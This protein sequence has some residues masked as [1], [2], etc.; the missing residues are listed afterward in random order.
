MCFDCATFRRLSDDALRRRRRRRKK[1]EEEGDDDAK[2]E[3]MRPFLVL[4]LLTTLFFCSLLGTRGDLHRGD[5]VPTSARMQV[6]SSKQR[7]QWMDVVEKH[8][9]SFGRNKM[10]AF[11]VE[12]PSQLMVD[13]LLDD[14]SNEIKIQFAFDNERHFTVWMPLRFYS[15]FSSRGK[16]KGEKKIPMITFTFTHYAGHIVNVKSGSSYIEKKGAKKQLHYQHF[17]AL[18]EEWLSSSLTSTQRSA[19]PKHVLLKYEFIEKESVDV[20][21]GLGVLMSIMLLVF[22]VSV[23]K[24]KIDEDD[25]GGDM[26]G[27][28]SSKLSR[29][30]GYKDEESNVIVGANTSEELVRRQ[31]ARRPSDFI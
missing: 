17:D 11:K 2:R 5:I 13:A 26:D 28:S 6:K 20:N 25:S 4:L 15:S 8:C 27:N 31:G 18:A 19:W 9:P 23:S 1:K 22:I 29:Q 21:K 7:T 3:R 24:M 12:K 10:I 16:T 14:K 30:K